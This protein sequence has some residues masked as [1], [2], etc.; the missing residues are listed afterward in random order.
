MVDVNFE[1]LARKVDE[2]NEK[3]LIYSLG[4]SKRLRG[5]YKLIVRR[6]RDMVKLYTLAGTL[7]QIEETLEDFNRPIVEPVLDDVR[8]CDAVDGDCTK[9]ADKHGYVCESAAKDIQETARIQRAEGGYC[10]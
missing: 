6:R 2:Y 1:S 10:Q 8:D 4:V 5:P 9:C 7:E 3:K